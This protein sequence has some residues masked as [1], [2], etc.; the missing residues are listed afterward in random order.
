VKYN[1]VTSLMEIEN[2]IRSTYGEHYV[3]KDDFQIQDLLHSIDIAVPFCQAN[4]MKYL[5]RYGK[6]KG[7]NR[8][9][10]LKAVHYII[11]LMHFSD[12]L[13]NDEDNS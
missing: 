11:L 5:A 2:Y 3:G 8:L 9:D 10:L 4:A 1:E 7:F 6:K 13:V 12:E